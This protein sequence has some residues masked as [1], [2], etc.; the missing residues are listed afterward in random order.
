MIIYIKAFHCII[1]EYK[2]EKAFK[3]LNPDNG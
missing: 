2:E 1:L 3:A